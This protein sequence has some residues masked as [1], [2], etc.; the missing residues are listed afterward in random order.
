MDDPGIPRCPRCPEL[1]RRLAELEKRLAD[2]QAKFDASQRSRKRQAAPFSKGS[3]KD[4]PKTPGRKAGESHGQHGHRPPPSPEQIDQI[5]EATLP[6]SCPDCGGGIAGEDAFDVQF[7]TDLP[8]KPVVRK[9]LIHKGCCTQCGRSV[10]GRHPL[11]TSDATGAAASQIGPD[12]QAAAAIL[13]KDAGLSHGKI[14]HVFQTILGIPLT[15]GASAQIVLRTADKLE[16]A[17]QEIQESIRNAPIITPDETGWRQGGRPVWL[18]AWVGDRATCYAIDPRR[19]AC[20]LEELI[21]PSYSGTLVHDGFASYDRFQD[22]TH[23]QCVAHALR[24]AHLL[25]ELH[26]GAAQAFPRQVIDLFQAAL[27][28][29]DA[30]RQGRLSDDDAMLAYEHYFARLWELTTRAR[31]NPLNAAFAK[32]LHKHVTDWF[33]FIIDPRIPATN[34]R[35]EQALRGPI[36]NRK[37]WGGNRTAAGS[38]AQA[39]L[40]SVLQTCKQQGRAVLHFL[41]KKIRGAIDNLFPNPQ[42]P[43]LIR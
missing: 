39:V 14:A 35:A 17:Y 12:A 16:P 33:A 26:T 43:A 25:E 29:R 13:N 20:V 32:H 24:R 31:R 2:L 30:G 7:Q 8:L 36:V 40:C 9:I 28:V 10:R 42:I 4:Q 5:L 37:V 38:R 21:G 41:S 22:A 19:S 27:E 3:P 34:Y 23:Q 1:E 18:H 15:R 11:Q 6:D